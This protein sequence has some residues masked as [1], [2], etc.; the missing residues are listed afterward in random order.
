MLVSE[1]QA[2]HWIKTIWEN[3]KRSIELHQEDKPANLLYKIRLRQLLGKF[4]EQFL[5][6][7]QNYWLE[8]KSGFH[9]KSNKPVHEYYNLLQNV[10]EENY[11][12]PP[13]VDSIWVAFNSM[14]INEL[15]QDLSLLVK[16]TKIEWET[17]STPDLINL[18][19]QLS[20]TLDESPKRKTAKIPKLQQV[21]PP[22]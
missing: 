19:N 2:Q 17:M 3:P 5:G 12:L 22:I 9:T 15:N 21:K 10:F 14:F 18:A 11:D 4:I 13:D 7:F 20:H 1:D 8:Q 16:G 6:L